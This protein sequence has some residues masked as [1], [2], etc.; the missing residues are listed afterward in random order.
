MHFRKVQGKQHL[1]MEG[2]LLI[3][4]ERTVVATVSKSAGP[5]KVTNARSIHLPEL[6]TR[7]KKL[8]ACI[9]ACLKIWR[10]GGK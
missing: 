7:G 5:A 4:R 9:I 8:R 1:D 3:T 10:E 6:T 2:D